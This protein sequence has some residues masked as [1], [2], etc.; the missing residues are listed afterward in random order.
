MINTNYTFRDVL[1]TISEVF[2]VI[3][4]SDM[5][6]YIS[7]F[8]FASI[9]YFNVIDQESV[10]R[11]ETVID[12]F[13]S[14][15]GGE[16]IYNFNLYNPLAEDV[17]DMYSTVKVTEEEYRNRCDYICYDVSEDATWY[18]MIVVV[19]AFMFFPAILVGYEYNK[20]IQ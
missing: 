4:F 19:L 10:Y 14:F 9:V 11:S 1:N 16:I 7:Y 3:E 17:E 13:E 12:H 6:I 2:D 15:D 18:D 5:F 20:M 8:T